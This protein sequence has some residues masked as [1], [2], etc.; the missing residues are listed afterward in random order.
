MEENPLKIRILNNKRNELLKRNEVIFIVY[1]N[2]APTPSRVEVRKGLASALKV[3]VDRVYIRKVESTTGAATSIGEAHLYDSTE[4]AKAI[5][6]K[7]IILRS[8]PQVKGE[9]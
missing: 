2:G 1:H 3:D 4:D 8:S 9:E 6:A 7:H 5:E